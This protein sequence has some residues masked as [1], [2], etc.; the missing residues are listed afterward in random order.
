MK[1]AGKIIEKKG[2]ERKIT[3]KGIPVNTIFVETLG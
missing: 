3:E 1:M 2:E